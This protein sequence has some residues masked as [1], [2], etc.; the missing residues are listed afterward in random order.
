M[1]KEQVVIIGSGCAGATA[2]VYTARAD[3]SPVIFEGMEPGGQLT[4]TSVIENYPGF[5]DGID[6]FELMSRMKS[7]AERFGARFEYGEVASL[8]KAE[9]G[10]AV[11]VKGRDT[12]FAKTV[13]VASG[14][15][16]RMLGLP[17]ERELT[18][19]GLSVCA[20]CDGAFF[21]NVPVSVVG[22]GDSVRAL[23]E[24][25]LAERVSWVSTGGG[26]SLELLE[27][28]TL[29]GVAALRDK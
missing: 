22:G 12:L 25:G 9:G 11:S 10:F 29:P 27:G 13:I 7:Q 1:E 5:V 3:L 20:T 8:T 6:G 15:R 21:R 28:R 17:R 18:G 19:H 2:A 16:A 24:A 26:A 23:V 14:A 4:T